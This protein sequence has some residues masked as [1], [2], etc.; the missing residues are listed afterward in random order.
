MPAREHFP[1]LLEIAVPGPFFFH[2]S[3]P[4]ALQRATEEMRLGAEF[5]LP[6]YGFTR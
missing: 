2:G 3:V 6:V 1:A 5:S 4:E